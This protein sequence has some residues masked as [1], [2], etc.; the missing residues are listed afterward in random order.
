M[1]A[2]VPGVEFYP[3]DGIS[4]ILVIVN[5]MNPA[6]SIQAARVPEKR[7]KSGGDIL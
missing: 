3:T 4:P 5:A 7:L 1:W 6:E 2:W